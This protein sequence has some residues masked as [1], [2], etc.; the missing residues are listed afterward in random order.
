MLRMIL[1]A[2]RRVEERRDSEADSGSSE[3]EPSPDDTSNGDCELESWVSWVRRTTQTVERQMRKS[4]IDSWMVAWR[5]R[6]WRWAQRVATAD[7]IRW[8]WKIDRWDA[9]LDAASRGRPAHRPV[10]RWTDDI[11]AFLNSK[12]IEVSPN[13]W[14]DVASDSA[15]WHDLEATFCLYDD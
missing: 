13:S 7:S 5:K 14:R 12:G 2:G 15:V 11:V 3:V 4:R 9:E 1:G 6:V 10:K 8:M